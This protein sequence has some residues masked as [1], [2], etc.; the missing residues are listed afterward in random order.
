MKTPSVTPEALKSEIIDTLRRFCDQRPGLEPGNYGSVQSY[1]E[2][3]RNITRDGQMARQLLRDV[4]NSSGIT[5]EAIIEAARHS[6]SGRLKIEV[7][8]PLHVRI[9]Y[10]PGQY[11]PT[12]YRKAVCAVCASALWDYVRT[13]CSPRADA[14]GL[15]QG[16]T[17]GDW[18]RKFFR[19]RYGRAIAVRWFD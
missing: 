15:I 1:R 10:T 6:Y 14:D 2:E 8:P 16:M 5:A 7:T 17:A 12:E 9:T 11:F 4:E 18:L 13:S 3:S 19:R